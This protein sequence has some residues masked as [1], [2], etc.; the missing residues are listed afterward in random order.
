MKNILILGS[1]GTIGRNTLEVIRSQKDRFNVF[2]LACKKNKKLLSAQIEEFKPS[3]VYIEKRDILFEKKFKNVK[4]FYGEEGIVEISTLKEVDFIIFAIPGIKTLKAFIEAIKEEKTIGLATKEI[5]VVA[6]EIIKKLKKKY[7]SEILPVDSEHNAI[8]QLIEREKKKEV[9]KIYLT[10][11][12]GPFWGKKVKNVKIKEVLNHPVWKMGKKVT[13]DSATMMNKCFEIIEAHYFFSL[14]Y[15]KIGVVIHPEAIIHGFVEFIDGTMKGIFHFPD[16]KYPINYVLNYPERVEIDFRNIN[17]SEI[18]K[19]TFTLP[20]E[21]S[22]WLV[23]ARKSL[24]EKGSYPVVLNGANEEAVNLFL[25]NKI[26]FNQIIKIVE[27]VISLH[28]LKKEVSLEEIYEIDK[29]AKEEVRKI[30]EEKKC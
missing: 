20:D 2:G 23:L 1:T 8:F 27:K 13:V 28:K 14:P 5:M 7:R 25:K 4:F 21:N 17:F 26:K 16:M 10:A 15:E 29:W 18:R 6:G 3:Y 19:L 9:K 24:E 11:S 12:G 22:P 30:V